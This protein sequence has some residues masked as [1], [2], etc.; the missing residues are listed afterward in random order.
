MAAYV[1]SDLAKKY[2]KFSHPVV[3]LKVDNKDFSKNKDNLSVSDIEVELTCGYEASI[4][5]F[6]IYNCFDI[7]KSTYKI[8]AVKDY[9][10]L[11]SSVEIAMGYGSEAAE[12][13][14]GFISRVNFVYPEND[15]PGIKVTAMDVK[16]IMMA[17]NNS[18]QLTANCYSD[19]IEEIF[20]KNIYATLQDEKVIKSLNITDTP[21]KDSQKA[22]GSSD[23]KTTDRTIEMVCESDYEFVVK[24]AKKYNYEFFTECGNVYFRKAKSDADVLMELSPKTGLRSLDVEYDITGLVQIVEARGMDTGKGKVISAKEKFSNAI[25]IGNDAKK[26]IKNSEMVYIDPTI[27]SEQEA[28]KRAESMMEDISYRFGTLECDCIG[29]PELLPGHFIELSGV[30]YPPENK[31]YVVSIRHRLIDDR[32]YETRIIG[33]AASIGGDNFGVI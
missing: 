17:N 5:S 25:S 15:M 8:S 28:K 11:G 18:R 29:I 2:N 4:A 14:T 19:A 27:T 21:D 32:G 31:F 13:F 1:F 24:V 26:L 9:I 10:K 22:I 23:K 20:K 3:V 6:V 7:S 33:K 12:V 16:G 30:G